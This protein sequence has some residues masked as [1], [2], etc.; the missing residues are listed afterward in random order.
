[1]KRSRSWQILL[2]VVVTLGFAP[3]SALDDSRIV[4]GDAEA[5]LLRL[6]PPDAGVTL[7]VADLRGNLATISGSRLAS[8][9]RELPAVKAWH[10]AKGGRELGRARSEIERMLGASMASIR[11]DLLGDALV[12]SLHLAP[13]APPESARGLL[14]AKVRDRAMLVRLV[15]LANQAE[16]ADGSLAGV[17][18]TGPPDRSYTVRS[19][20]PG[21]K[22]EREYYRVFDDGTFAWSNSEDLIRGVL[23]RKAGVGPGLLDD[24]GFRKVRRG[25]P[26]RSI[27]TVHINPKFAD[28]VLAAVPRSGQPGDDRAAEI[29]TRYIR[30]VEGIGLALEWRDG[31]LIHSH[32]VFDPKSLDARLLRWARSKSTP[33]T[34]ARRIPNTALAAAVVPI[35]F[36]AAYDAIVDL[37][38]VADRPRLD[39]ILVALQGVLLGRDVRSEIIPRIGPALIAYVEAPSADSSRF[40]MVGVVELRDEMGQRGVAAA[41]DNALRTLLALYSLDPK[42]Q[43]VQLRIESRQAGPIRVTSLGGPGVPF[44]YGVGPDCLVVGTSADAVARFGTAEP[45]THLAPFKARYFPDARAYAALDIARLSAAA[46]THRLSLAKKFA[47]SRGVSPEAAARDLDQAIALLDLFEGAFFAV[48]VDPE[49]TSVHQTVGLVGR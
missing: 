23:D 48:A 41:I 8:S 15:E 11:D 38:P 34:L 12:L 3:A 26:S 24:P 37:I 22:K 47:S 21:S 32:E 17:S 27:L 14:L 16:T 35:D 25:L 33:D 13:G 44:A 31:L 36:E 7:S 29:L 19:F 49:L 6:V 5:G 45:D 1:M 30:S 4:P 46:R 20:K 43:A 39:T 40:P 18:T 10:D 9:F 2:A 28:R 42:R